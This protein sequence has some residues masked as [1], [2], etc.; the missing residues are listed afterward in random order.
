MGKVQDDIPASLLSR[1][2][3]PVLPRMNLSD[4]GFAVCA[5]KFSGFHRDCL[6]T[7]LLRVNFHSK[8]ALTFNINIYM[9]YANC[10]K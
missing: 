8:N 4:K 2:S 5:F 10:A 3:F 6:N 1:S 7:I 9:I